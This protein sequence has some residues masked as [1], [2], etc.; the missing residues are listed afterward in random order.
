M[1][2]IIIKYKLLIFLTN[3]LICQY[4]EDKEMKIKE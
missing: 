4:V 2:K 3:K 1:Y